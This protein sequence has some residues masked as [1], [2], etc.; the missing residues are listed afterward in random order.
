[1]T[2][3]KQNL[4]L[5]FCVTAVFDK[6]TGGNGAFSTVFPLEN[7]QEFLKTDVLS[8]DNDVAI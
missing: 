7:D 3:F 2:L 8:G 5:L 4:P 6:G 1:L